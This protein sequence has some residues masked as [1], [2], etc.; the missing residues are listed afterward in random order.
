M[1]HI[2]NPLDIRIHQVP[3]NI[4]HTYSK[5]LSKSG[6]SDRFLVIS[7]VG[8][9]DLIV[10]DIHDI[11]CLKPFL[12]LYVHFEIRMFLGLNWRIS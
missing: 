2:L 6:L 7:D 11:R 3:T 12:P 1:I 8:R 4:Y 10:I 5:K 9:P